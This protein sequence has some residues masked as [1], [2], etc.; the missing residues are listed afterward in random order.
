MDG[1]VRLNNAAAF[2]F[3]MRTRVSLS[4]G[5]VKKWD[6]AWAPANHQPCWADFDFWT[7]FTCAGSKSNCL[8][9]HLLPLQHW[10]TPPPR[11][12]LGPGSAL[13]TEPFLCARATPSNGIMTLVNH[14]L[15]TDMC[16]SVSSF[17]QTSPRAVSAASF[18]PKYRGHTWH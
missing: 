2:R 5:E 14:A 7:S 6:V 18:C 8:D 10:L 17:V 13:H 11:Q 3:V 15:N 16:C 1:R 9:H 4:G 12:S